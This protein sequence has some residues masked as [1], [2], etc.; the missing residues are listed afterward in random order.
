MLSST[1]N[2]YDTSLRYDIPVD[3]DA[4]MAHNQQLQDSLEECLREIELLKLEMHQKEVRIEELEMR[5]NS[6]T[7]N[8]SRESGSLEDTQNKIGA[9]IMGEEVSIPKELMGDFL[10][11]NLQEFL[12]EC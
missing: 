2:G 12:D 9:L 10:G 4:L 3:T 5:T 6:N 7:S 8:E 1:S 11:F